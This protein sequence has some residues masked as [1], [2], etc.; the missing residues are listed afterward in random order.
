MAPAGTAN[1]VDGEW[2]HGSTDGE[3][4]TVIKNGV[5]PAFDML[6]GGETLSDPQIWNVVNYLRSIAPKGLRR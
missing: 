4:F 2:K 5:G 1:L 6:P 3:I